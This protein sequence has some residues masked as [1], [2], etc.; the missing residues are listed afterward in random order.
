M[1][2]FEVKTYEDWQKAVEEL[3]RL[4]AV[5]K[6]SAL[7]ATALRKRD[8]YD[9]MTDWGEKPVKIIYKDGRYSFE[10]PEGV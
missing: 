10:F 8:R 9:I 4:K 7:K 2:T 6:Y 5:G 3:I 1:K